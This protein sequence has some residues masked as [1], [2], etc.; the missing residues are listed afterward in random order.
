V[1][2]VD[3]ARNAIIVGPASELGGQRLQVIDASFVAGHLP[4]PPASVSAKIR[5]TGREVE[6]TLHLGE[7]RIVDVCLAAPVRDIA[8]G[9]AA[10][11]YQGEILL[12]GGIIAKE[13]TDDG[14]HWIGDKTG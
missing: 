12:G 14:I 10:V 5:Y 1:L 6:A 8:P 4:R 13:E 11:F 9:Q 3:A 7:D 2:K